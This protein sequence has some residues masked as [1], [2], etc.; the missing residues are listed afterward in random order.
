[1]TADVLTLSHYRREHLP[2]IRPTLVAVYAE[3][4]DQNADDPFHSVERF[5]ERLSGHASGASWA[6][7]VGEIDGKPVGFA[8]GRLDSVREWREVLHP[9]DPSVRDYGEQGTFGLCEI[10][11]RLPW[12]GK[13][14]ARGIHD[15]L[16]EHRSED[17]ASLLVDSER[18]KVRSM[19]E[20]WGYR[21]VGQMQPFKDSPLFDAMAVELH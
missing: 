15:E 10:M 18:P 13:G 11:V 7:V 5:E 2:L 17:R 3:V 19:Y 16:M 9:I 1:M 20:S 8:Y 14:I 6:C 21:K 4:Y 12:R